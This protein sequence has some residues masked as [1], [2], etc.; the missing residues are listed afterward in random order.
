M[1]KADTSGVMNMVGR[2]QDLACC[3]MLKG[4]FIYPT[5]HFAR[6]HV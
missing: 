2:L 5:A 6:V 3:V 1:V 4:E